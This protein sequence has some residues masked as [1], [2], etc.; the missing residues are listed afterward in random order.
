MSAK[1]VVVVTTRIAPGPGDAAVGE[2]AGDGLPPPGPQAAR[3]TPRATKAPSL[4]RIEFI[5]RLRLNW[6]AA[7]V[8]DPLASCRE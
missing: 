2:P 8:P 7:I 5:M 4:A 6:L 3:T 1:T